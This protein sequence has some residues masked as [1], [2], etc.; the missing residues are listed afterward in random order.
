[1]NILLASGGSGGHMAPAI[2]IAERLNEHQC[3]FIT[4]NR[5]VDEAFSKKYS[6]FSFVKTNALPFKISPIAF[7]KFVASQ[8]SSFRFALRLLKNRK[9]DL[10]ISFGGFTSFVFVLAA[11]VKKIP[12]ILYEPNVI[13]GKAFRLATRFADKILLPEHVSAEYQRKKIERVGFPIRR[14]FVNLSKADARALLGWPPSK[15]IILIIG[16]SAGAATLNKWAQQNFM[17]F[18]HH[19]IDLYCIAGAG[20]K[21][22]QQVS[23]EDCTLHML[24]F[25]ENMNAVLRACDLVIARAGAGTIG[26]CQFCKKPM[27][28]VPH[29]GD[30]HTH[31]LANG[32]RAE[33]QGTAIVIEQENLDILADRAI[34]IISN[35]TIL[36]IMQRY[37]ERAFVPD[38]AE[39][40]AHT[41]ENFMYKKKNKS[42]TTS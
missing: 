5:K 25:C 35:P 11:K 22:E 31:Q 34:E 9:I 40:I 32:R 36:S 24:P 6:Q 3:T 33:Q 29:G 14:E 2:A 37:L 17:R 42:E 16:G 28:L 10:V 8:I 21:A 13:P 26:E 39:Q 15:K 12:S 30:A 19:N 27:I 23:F 20:L 18:A 1:M 7:F 41:I 38:S 4:S